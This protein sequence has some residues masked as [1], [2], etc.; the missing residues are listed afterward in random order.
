MRERRGDIW[1][2][3]GIANAIC[4]TTNGILKPD[5]SLIMGAGIA[6]QAARKFPGIDQ[7]LGA[8]VKEKGNI[9]H[10]GAIKEGTAIVSFPTKY[11]WK[12]DSSL[13]LILSSVKYLVKM[14]EKYNWAYV[15][16]PRPGCGLGNLNWDEVKKVIEPMLDY[17]FV[18]CTP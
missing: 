6:L 18:I 17:R 9:P 5:G 2:L 8:K 13:F 7:R 3:I 1:S 11:D 15:A 12:D 14:A 16:M 4:V 10:T